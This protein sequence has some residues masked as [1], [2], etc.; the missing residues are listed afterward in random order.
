MRLESDVMAS[1]FF[2][3]IFEGLELIDWYAV[4]GAYGEAESVPDAL[5]ALATGSEQQQLAAV[6]TLR[7]GL[8]HQGTIYYPTRFSIPFL[9]RLLGHP[10]CLVATDI[11]E[12]LHSFARGQAY[13]TQHESLFR[14]GGGFERSAAALDTLEQIKLIERDLV[15]K[16]RQEVLLGVPVY[17]D[18]LRATSTAKLKMRLLDLLEICW[19]RHQE[20]ARALA[21]RFPQEPSAT[22]RAGILLTLGRLGY[23]CPQLSGELCR[24]VRSVVEAD[25]EAPVVQLAAGLGQLWLEP[26]E[27]RAA[28]LD[29]LARNLAAGYQDLQ[30]LEIPGGFA[31]TVFDLLAPEDQERWLDIL[32]SQSALEAKL[33]VASILLRETGSQRLQSWFQRALA[34]SADDR[35]RAGLL[36]AW[37]SELGDDKQA[38]LDFI[39]AVVDVFETTEEPLCR[40]V[41]ATILISKQQS[42]HEDAAWRALVEKLDSV[43][44]DYASLPHGE[45]NPLRW[46][47]SVLAKKPRKWTKPLL[48]LAQ[49]PD[50]R[51]GR[52]AEVALALVLENLVEAFQ[53]Q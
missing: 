12:L 3:D 19:E 53:S 25:N 42:A 37:D 47:R 41:T 51:I 17:L 52:E 22:V 1:S 23:S 43:W 31:V 13:Y 29:I 33:E 39:G 48:E 21:D 5:R 18:L 2:E 16:T 10:G 34:E 45:G 50:H 36:L 11:V 20:I 35:C 40:V 14:D 46:L 6:H 27:R 8:E 30:A 32:T 4:R 38:Q 15:S 24:M 9:I 7:G 28:A 49:H 44:D 26:P